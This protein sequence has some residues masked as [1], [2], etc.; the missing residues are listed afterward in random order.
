MLSA[1][2]RVNERTVALSPTQDYTHGPTLEESH[3]GGFTCT[4]TGGGASG[5]G[6]SS[7]GSQPAAHSRLVVLNLFIIDSQLPT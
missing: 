4:S 3:V 6:R 5:A 2:F 7:C 1:W